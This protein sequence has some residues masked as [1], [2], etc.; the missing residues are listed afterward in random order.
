MIKRLLI[1]ILITTVFF[2]AVQAL[3]T[4]NA[5]AASAPVETTTFRSSFPTCE[6]DLTNARP[7]DEASLSAHAIMWY[8]ETSGWQCDAEVTFTGKLAARSREVLNWL[9]QNYGWSNI[10]SGQEHLESNIHL[11]MV[12]RETARNQEEVHR[13]NRQLAHTLLGLR[14]QVKELG[15]DSGQTPP[16]PPRRIYS[17]LSCLGRALGRPG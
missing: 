3:F 4:T 11:P 9:L 10:Q 7:L 13:Q 12:R 5:S 16:R 14:L 6:P 8:N 15:R 2:G 17:G 1:L